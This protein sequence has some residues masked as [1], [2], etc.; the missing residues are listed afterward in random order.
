MTGPIGKADW[1]EPRC[2]MCD[3]PG[4]IPQQRMM[5]KL[6]EYMSRRDYS[7]AERHLNYWLAEARQSADARGE[8]LVLNEMIGHY[9]KTGN[10]EQALLRADEA[11]EL[12]DRLGYARSRT[13]G[14]TCVNAATALQAFGEN[15]KALRLFERARAVYESDPDI[16]GAL[17]GGLYNN[18]ALARAALQDWPEAEEL[19]EKALACMAKVPGGRLESAITLLNLADALQ[20]RL[21]PEQAESRIS[22]LVDRAVEYLEA[23]DAPEDGYYAFVLE[24]CV[25]SLQYYGYFAAADALGRKAKSIYERA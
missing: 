22:D 20:A 14:T 16:P 17:L 8:L 13:G 4:G 9:R 7:G 23:P 25:P 1:Q 21:G 5:R 3:V 6:D 15:E 19:Y 24:K 2:L 18:M 12:N 11:L 10:R